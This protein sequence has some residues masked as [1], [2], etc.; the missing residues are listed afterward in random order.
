MVELKRGNLLEADAEAFVNTV[1]TVGVMGKGIAL[2]F[3]RAFPANYDAYARAAKAGRI[4]IGE[5][6]VQEVG[7][8]HGP[9]WI[10]NFPTKRHWRHASKLEYVEAGL[11]ALVDEV[12]RRNITSIAVPPLGCGNGGL[13][14]TVVRQRIEAAFA[15]VPHVRVLLYEPAGAPAP[16]KMVT[17]TQRPN[18]TPGRAALITLMQRY[19]VPGYDYPLTLIEVQKLAY[20]MQ[21]AGQNL[22][23]DFVAHHYGP[24]ADDLRHVLDHV[25]GQ[26][27]RGYGDGKT[28]PD[29]PMEI[30]P[31]AAEE[32]AKLLEHDDAVQRRLGSVARLIEGFETPLGMELLSSVHWVATHD[33][34]ARRD[35]EAAVKAVHD[36]RERKARL[37]A[38]A[39]I[40]AA[41]T[42]LHE[43][44]WI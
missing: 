10:I 33:A 22:R 29:T 14:W 32:A 9:R 7:R 38:P 5:M 28:S 17:R 35:P 27:L 25:E 12:R 15:A 36:W 11:K 24:Y 34:Q 6:F 26:F 2:Q 18:M 31:G 1:N 41:W 4:Q 42:R 19:R 37:M 30:L 16:A 8:L 44:E 39:Q 23:L 3:K 40:R 20:L 13:N 43:Q 21:A